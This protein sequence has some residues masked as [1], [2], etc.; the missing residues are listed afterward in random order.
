MAEKELVQT[1]AETDPEYLEEA[2]EPLHADLGDR[3]KPRSI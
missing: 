2:Q 3:L 1:V